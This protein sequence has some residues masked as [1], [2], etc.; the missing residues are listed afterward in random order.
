MTAYKPTFNDRFP[1]L[2]SGEIQ[3]VQL[4][5]RKNKV[6]NFANNLPNSKAEKLNP[7]ILSLGLIRPLKIRAL[8]YEYYSLSRMRGILRPLGM[9]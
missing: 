9:G 2:F 3:F 5:R 7:Q 6:K 1:M 8:P 4:H